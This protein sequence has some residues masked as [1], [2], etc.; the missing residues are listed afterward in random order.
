MMTTPFEAFSFAKRI[1]ST[2]SI[3]STTVTK[4]DHIHLSFGF[5]APHL[6]PIEELSQAAYEAVSLH[7]RT[8]L[9][10]SGSGGPRKILE[11]IQNRSLVH[12]IQAELPQI[13]V[14][15]GSTQGIDIAA[16]I[17]LDPGDH[18]WVESPSFFSALQAFRAAEAVITSFPIDE[19]GLRV[20]LVEN[21]LLE[22]R[23][24]N[25]PIPKFVYTMPT[26][27]N[28]GGVTLTTERRARLAEL[29]ETYN[30][31]IVEDDAYSELNFTGNKY[32]PLYTLLP[33]RVIYLNTFSK[34]IGPGLRLGWMIADRRVIDKARLL[35]LG[36]S[37]GV[38]TQEIL[39][40]LL[41]RLAFQEHVDQLSQHYHKQRDIMAEAIKSSFGDHVTFHLPEGGFYI[42]LRF[43]E[44][45]NTSDFLREAAE[46]G[47]SFVD[48]KSFFAK[49]EGYHYARLCFSYVSEEQILRGVNILADAYFAYEEQ[50]LFGVTKQRH[51]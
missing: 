13:L 49:P 14:T 34:I 21:A 39:A 41:D 18:V 6:F 24:Q 2:P 25:K 37:I 28:P 35:N 46:R 10:Y 29:A 43:G 40:Q 32:P 51:L 8:A 23:R 12:G 44:A 27:H 3:G 50:R 45:V 30:F 16:R 5:A 17:L 42:W 48:G 26:Y 22:A 4:P 47:V 7:G 9:Q 20:D 36:G 38:F 33:G 19:D 11:W 15:Y 1:P 31:F